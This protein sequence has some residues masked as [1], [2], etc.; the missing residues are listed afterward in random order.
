MKTCFPFKVTIK[1]GV[2]SINPIWKNVISKY[3]KQIFSTQ[4]YKK[5]LVQGG[6]KIFL[7]LPLAS[8]MHGQ[9]IVTVHMLSKENFQPPFPR[10]KEEKFHL[11]PW[12]WPQRKETKLSL[13]E[14]LQWV[15]NHKHTNSPLVTV[16]HFIPRFLTWKELCILRTKPDPHLGFKL[17]AERT[18]IILP[19][20]VCLMQHLGSTEGDAGSSILHMIFIFTGEIPKWKCQNHYLFK[21]HI[22]LL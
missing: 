10:M 14:R 3:I 15:T 2:A 7:V 6:W 11:Q 12:N 16:G 1:K 20:H 17:K 9:K 5:I 18:V 21:Y 8:T 22:F 4:K 19:R 13:V